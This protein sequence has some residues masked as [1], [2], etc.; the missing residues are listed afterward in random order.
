VLGS[1]SENARANET[2][3]LLNWGYT[4]Y[5]AVKLF[6][7]GPGGGHRQRSGKG[8]ASPQ[9]KAGRRRP[10]I[11]A[12]PAGTRRQTQDPSRRAQTRWWRL[13]PRAKRVG[14]LEGAC[15]ATKPGGLT[16]RLLALDRS[17]EQARDH[18]VVALGR[19]LRLW[20]KLT[21]KA[22]PASGTCSLRENP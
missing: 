22:C 12:V 3:K 16:C 10:S 15:R 6:D 19:I 7:A 20:I 11:V 14:S 4:A 17:M 8:K 1:Q 18:S 9:V 2:Q 21:R 5:E 13:S